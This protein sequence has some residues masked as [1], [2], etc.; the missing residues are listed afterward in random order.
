MNKSEHH[1]N[2][3]NKVKNP[4]ASIMLRHIKFIDIC[5]DKRNMTHE[6]GNKSSSIARICN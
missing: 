1:K 4:P 3:T 6:H 5:I 2:F